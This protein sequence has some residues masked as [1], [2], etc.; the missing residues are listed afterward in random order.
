MTV[1]HKTV[2]VILEKWLNGQ[3]KKLHFGFFP[4]GNDSHN[5]DLTCEELNC[6]LD[7]S[8]AVLLQ[9]AN[10]KSS[11]AQRVINSSLE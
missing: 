3:L 10:N 7:L 6:F 1:A 5:T 9:I 2:L 8:L 4:W 11:S